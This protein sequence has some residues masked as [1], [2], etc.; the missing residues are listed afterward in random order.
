MFCTHCGTTL[1]EGQRFCSSCGKTLVTAVAAESRVGQHLT[2]V[3]VFWIVISGFRLVGAVMVLAV[4]MFLFPYIPAEFSLPTGIFSTL[5]SMVGGG[6]LLT[7]FAGLAAGFGLLGRRS[8]ARILAVIMA[9]LSLLEIPFGT[10][11]AIYTLW[12]LLPAE[13]E[14]EY[15]RLASGG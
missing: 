7:A 15:R 9:F 11:L 10:A 6:L 12:V 3:G 4:G 5:V 2:L 8:W 13:R 1:E 14:E